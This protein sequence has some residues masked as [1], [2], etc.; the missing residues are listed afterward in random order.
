[1]MTIRSGAKQKA[2]AHARMRGYDKR[3]GDT[4]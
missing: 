3:R 1:M 4:A 2:H